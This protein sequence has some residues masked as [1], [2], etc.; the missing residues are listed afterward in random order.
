[1][2][3]TSKLLALA[4]VATMQSAMAG[5][6]FLDFEDVQISEPL[7]DRYA[8]Q[9]VSVSGAAWTATS[10][11][12]LYGGVP[13]EVSFKRPGSCGALWLAEDP[14][15]PTANPLRS[16]TMTLSDGFDALSFV[17]SG[18]RSDINLS[19]HAFDASGAEVGLGLGGLTGSGCSSFLFCNWSNTVSLNLQ[20]GTARTVVFT[21]LD[22]TILI[23]DLSFNTPTTGRLPEP[24]SAA[25]ALGAIGA[26]GWSRRRAAR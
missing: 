7:T 10:E 14:T 8:A 5:V 6:V 21:G 25:L 24:T 12:C 16:L 15:Q 13:G 2:R 20:G 26:L 3:T 17:Y 9:H 23:D 11:A 18:S 19:V 4:L 1:M 22:Q